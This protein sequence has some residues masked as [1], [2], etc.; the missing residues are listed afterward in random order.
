MRRRVKSPIESDVEHIKEVIVH[1]E[2]D[3]NFERLM[4]FPPFEWQNG[5]YR[6][7][8]AK[9]QIP[10]ALDIPTGL[11][12]TRVMAL[13][14]IALAA[15]ANLPRRLV[16]VV[17]RRAV[18]DQATRFAEQLRRNMPTVL[19]DRLRLQ[20]GAGALPISTLRGGFADNRD[21]LA[22]IPR[23]SRR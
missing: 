12:K 11:G 6:D 23:V 19:A 18:V 17:D 3:S 9:G 10:S 5:L 4:G 22:G 14:L 1:D 8:F 2:F 20:D 7:Y 16:Y 15:R 13:W 21:W